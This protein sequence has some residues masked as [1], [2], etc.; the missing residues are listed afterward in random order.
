MGGI[1]AWKT[2]LVDR[3]YTV[4]VQLNKSHFCSG[5]STSKGEEGDIR[6]GERASSQCSTFGSYT[7]FPKSRSSVVDDLILS[8]RV[9]MSK[10]A[11]G[12]QMGSGNKSEQAT[13][14]IV[15][16]RVYSTSRLRYRSQTCLGWKMRT[17][18]QAKELENTFSTTPKRQSDIDIYI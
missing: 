8:K 17:P 12:S 14:G 10:F 13:R 3:A 4:R 11:R 9:Q 7:P 5:Q 6:E 1:P 15:K 18:L 2:P 16:R